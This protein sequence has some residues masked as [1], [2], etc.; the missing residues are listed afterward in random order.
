MTQTEKHIWLL[1]TL[2]DSKLTHGLTLRE[3]S[4]KWIEKSGKPLDRS[5]FNRWRDAIERQWGVNIECSSGNEY[6]YSITNPEAIEE[7]KVGKWIVDSFSMGSALMD[8][9]DLHGRILLERI[10]SGQ[11]Y[12]QPIIR[13]MKAGH[14][15]RIEYH[16]FGAP[17]SLPCE[18][19]PLCLKLYHNRWY[20]VGAYFKEG[21]FQTRVYGLDRIEGVTPL[22]ESFSMPE[23]FDGEEYFAD[24]MGVSIAPEAKVWPIRLRVSNP[25]RHYVLSLPLHHSQRVV[26]DDGDFAEIELTLA[27]TDEFFMEILHGGSSIEILSPPEVVM[28]MKGWVNELYYVYNTD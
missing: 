3:L 15:I 10:P 21:K 7:E 11:T 13:A 14:R 1:Q 17:C 2:L 4:E 24:Y 27:P 8:T 25:Q 22:T 5:T 19:S 26:S 18:I 6:K 28:Q 12:L 9:L 16:K 20:I 23:D